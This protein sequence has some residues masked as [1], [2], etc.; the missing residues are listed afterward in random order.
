MEYDKKHDASKY[1]TFSFGECKVL[2]RQDKKLVNDAVI[3]KWVKNGI[4]RELEYK[5]LKRVDSAA[6]LVVTYA[7]ITMPRSDIQALGPLGQTPGSDATTWSREYNQS[8]LIIDLNN[9]HNF[10]VWRINAIADVVGPES[11]RTI[12]MI[13]EKGFKKFAKPVKKKKR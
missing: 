7:M 9:R 5:G 12:D 13:V 4:I 6:D 2:T 3:D 10:L 8:S 1:K 11:E